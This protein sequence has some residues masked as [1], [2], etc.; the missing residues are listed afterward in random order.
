MRRATSD[1]KPTAAA[2]AADPAAALGFDDDD[3]LAGLEPGHAGLQ[4]AHFLAKVPDRSLMLGLE[5]GQTVDLAHDA[6]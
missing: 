2:L 5:T 4:F 6:P 3:V 1:M